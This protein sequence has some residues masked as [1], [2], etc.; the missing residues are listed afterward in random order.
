V[1]YDLRVTALRRLDLEPLLAAGADEAGGELVW[2]RETLVAQL[3]PGDRELEVGVVGHEAPVERRARDFR[4]V[5]AVLLAI[6][7]RGGGVV[8]DPQLGR[9]LGPDDVDAAVQMF[10]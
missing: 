1:S 10:A 8:H 7:E 4:E 6:A 3:L 2:T 5:L 9:D